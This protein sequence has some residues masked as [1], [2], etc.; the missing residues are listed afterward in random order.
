MKVVKWLLLAFF[1]LITLGL[2]GVSPL[3]W[4]GIILIVFGIYQKFQQSKEK[5]RFRDQVW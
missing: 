4:I 2:V 3:V 1:S 5:L